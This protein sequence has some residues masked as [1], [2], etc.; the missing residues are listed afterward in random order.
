VDELRPL[1]DSLPDITTNM[2]RYLLLHSYFYRS[3][4]IL[5]QVFT[6]GISPKAIVA[7]LQ[8]NAVEL[9]QG[10][11]FFYEGKTL[12]ASQ[13][14]SQSFY[15]NLFPDDSEETTFFVVQYLLKLKN[16]INS[17]DSNLPFDLQQF[18][19]NIYQADDGLFKIQLPTANATG[20]MGNF[21]QPL[22]LPQRMAKLI[23]KSQAE[24][25]KK[26]SAVQPASSALTNSFKFVSDLFDT[27]AKL[28]TYLVPATNSPRKDTDSVKFEKAV[29]PREILKNDVAANLTEN[30]KPTYETFIGSL[31]SKDFLIKINPQHLSDLLHEMVT[32]K[33]REYPQQ[34][35]RHILFV[36]SVVLGLIHSLGNQ[37]SLEYIQKVEAVTLLVLKKTGTF[38]PDFENEATKAIK[39]MISQ[40]AYRDSLSIDQKKL[41]N[42]MSNK[43]VA[44]HRSKGDHLADPHI[45]LDTGSHKA[46]PPAYLVEYRG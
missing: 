19:K 20:D 1:V 12:I 22:S 24:E 14:V 2:G 33:N 25:N 17:R 39:L 4:E 10:V 44:Y 11:S 9:A 13:K 38:A 42:I 15:Q 43:I 8:R 5:Q 31:R 6:Q 34:I 32:E 27:A 28:G 21:S 41:L 7:E 40:M 23:E 29:N 36:Q 3:K 26:A 16:Q 37:A 46:F 18:Y 45:Y 35:N 30:S